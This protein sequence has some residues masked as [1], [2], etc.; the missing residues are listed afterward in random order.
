MPVQKDKGWEFTSLERFDPAAYGAANGAT[1][2]APAHQPV[3]A[4]AE[5]ELPDGVIAGSLAAAAEEHPEL[6]GKHLG[7]LVADSDKFSAQNTAEWKDG[8]FVYVPAGVR[9]PDPI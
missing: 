6:V 8:A 7:S 4:G 1:T 5:I 2:T 3:I 9:V